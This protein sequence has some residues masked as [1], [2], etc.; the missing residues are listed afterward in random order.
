MYSLKSRILLGIVFIF[1][2]PVYLWASDVAG[3]WIAKAPG[4]Q[5]QEAIDIILEF[6]V[7]GEKLTGTLNN[8]T[9]E[10]VDLQDGKVTGDEVYFYVAREFRSTKMKVVWKGKISGD[11]IKFVRTVEIE[12][13]SPGPGGGFPPTE[14]IARRAKQD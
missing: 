14:I 9:A 7:D 12:G 1:A 3:T 5:G 13:A 4:Q 11:E 8:P 6:N 10:L 2:L